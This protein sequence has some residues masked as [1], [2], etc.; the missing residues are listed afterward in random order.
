MIVKNVYS[1][2]ILKDAYAG[3]IIGRTHNT[4]SDRIHV[5]YSVFNGRRITG[6]D[7]ASKLNDNTTTGNAKDLNDIQGQLYQFNGI[8]R[9]SRSR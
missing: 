1:S 7:P 9:L 4:F 5:E 6:E 8:E 3:E 2:G